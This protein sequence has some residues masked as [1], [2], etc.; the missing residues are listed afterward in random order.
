MATPPYAHE[1]R[2]GDRYEPFEFT[3]THDLNQQ[4]LFA[5]EDYHPRYIDGADGQPP[6]VHPI[7]LMQMSPRTRSPS[8]RQAPDLGSALARDCTTFLRPVPVGTRLKVEWEVTNT[9]EQRHK[10]YQD[11]VATILDPEGRVVMRREISSTFFSLAGSQAQR[12]DQEKSA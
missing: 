7:M 5:V 4:W 12:L 2:A 1:L 3:A 6:L 8:F 10:I 9:Y 11:Y